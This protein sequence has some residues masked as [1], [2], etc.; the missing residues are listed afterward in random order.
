ML[1]RSKNSNGSTT[2]VYATEALMVW[3]DLD[4]YKHFLPVWEGEE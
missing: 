4:C 3:G 1:H 2:A